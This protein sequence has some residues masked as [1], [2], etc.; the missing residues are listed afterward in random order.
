LSPAAQTTTC[1]VQ[2]GDTLARIAARFGTTV[3]AIM[4]VNPQ[5]TSANRIYAGQRL[6]IPVAGGPAAQRISFAAG[7]TS[8]ARDDSVAAGAS[9]RYVFR[10]VAGQ[11]ALIDVVSGSGLAELA[12]R[13]ANGRVVMDYTAAVTS[14]RAPLPTSQDY[15]IE[16]RGAGGAAVS[17]TL[18][19]TIPERIRFTP[20]AISASLTGFVPRFGTH[21][22]ILRAAAGQTMTVDVQA[23]GQVILIVYGNDGSVLQTDHSGS[24][25]FSGRLPYTQD[26]YLD[27]RS[28]GPAAARY[29]L[30]VRITG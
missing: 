30:D 5:V 11:V 15:Y 26:Y 8:A 17:Y 3:S 19:L 22:Y 10:A 12:I 13:G 21:N 23:V 28:L 1:V 4:S 25:S 14:F 20:G 9:K 16:V 2:R 27:V 7:T 6:Q 18:Q 24:T 29:R